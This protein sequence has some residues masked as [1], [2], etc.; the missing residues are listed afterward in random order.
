MEEATVSVGERS[1][2]CLPTNGDRSSRIFGLAPSTPLIPAGRTAIKSRGGHEARI[3]PLPPAEMRPGL[4]F[5]PKKCRLAF[6][7]DRTTRMSAA[8]PTAY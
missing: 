2:R 6:A 5:P 7:C 1:K 8:A 3:E 4:E